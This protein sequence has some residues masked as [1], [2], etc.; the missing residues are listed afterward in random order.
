MGEVRSWGGW[1]RD[2]RCPTAGVG[3]LVGRASSQGVLGVS[4]HRAWVSRTGTG[5]LVSRAKAQEMP[6]LLLA[7][8]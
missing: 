5:M 7:Q 4:G 2:A 3:L 8:W 6:W 1:L